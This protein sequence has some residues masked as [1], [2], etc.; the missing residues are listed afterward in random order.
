MISGNNVLLAISLSASV[1]L[2]ATAQPDEGQPAFRTG[3]ELINVTATVT[4]AR[5][6]FVPGLT[7]DDFVVYE[8]GRQVDV[9]YFSNERAPVSLA[10]AL[11]TSGSMEGRKMA[12]ARN[13]LDRFLYNLLGPEDEILLYRFS[14]TPELLQAWTMDRNR[15][16]R[17]LRDIRPRGGTAMYDAVAESIPQIA[18]G[19]H[20]KKALLIISD[21]NDTNSE[22]DLQ[23]LRALIRENETL[24]YAIGL[25]RD[26]H[27]RVNRHIPTIGFP[28]PRAPFPFPGRGNPHPRMP[29]GGPQFPV[30]DRVN[31]SALRDLTDESGGRTEIIGDPN[32]LDPVTADLAR[33]LSQHYYLVYPARSEP[34]GLWH[35]IRVETNNSSYRVRARRGYVAAR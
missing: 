5:G 10:I 26:E 30:D 17:S 34:D 9:T 3:I 7:Q 15:I 20:R 23:T 16:S 33:E 11:D 18:D 6:R 8:D 2:T 28:P 1:P 35:T 24:I 4:D 22:T 13:A 25:D 27:R 21:G 19:Q 31:V 12:A 29:Q 32:D 14:Y